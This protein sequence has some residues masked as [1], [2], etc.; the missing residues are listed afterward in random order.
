MEVSEFLSAVL[1][2][3]SPS[4]S[5]KASLIASA[6]NARLEVLASHRVLDNSSQEAQILERTPIARQWTPGATGSSV[7]ALPR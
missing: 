2:I 3:Y 7:E 4:L 1:K 5:V 6:Y